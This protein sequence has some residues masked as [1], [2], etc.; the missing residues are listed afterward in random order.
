MASP[1]YTMNIVMDL[2]HA[3]LFA[4]M[5][6]EAARAE[7]AAVEKTCAE[8]QTMIDTK[9]GGLRELSAK[10]KR[11]PIALDLQRRY[12]D[13]IVRRTELRRRIGGMP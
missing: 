13:A 1:T 10:A 3:E 9:Y 7:L 12:Q 5:D 4:G 6:D 2:K 8:L 11:W